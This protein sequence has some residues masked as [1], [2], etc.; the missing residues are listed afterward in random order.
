MS[1]EQLTAYLLSIVDNLNSAIELRME[2]LPEQARITVGIEGNI[3]NPE[4]EIYPS[5][6]PI[7]KVKE[8]LYEQIEA[9]RGNK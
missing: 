6:D 3:F 9:L 4:R 8:S 7:L 5:L 1:N 2:N